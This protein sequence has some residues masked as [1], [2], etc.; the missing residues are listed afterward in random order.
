MEVLDSSQ[1]D[2]VSRG[3]EDQGTTAVF[4]KTGS[5]EMIVELENV[6][7]SDLR[8]MQRSIQN[9]NERGWLKKKL[10][11]LTVSFKKPIQG[12]IIFLFLSSGC[13][14][15][16]SWQYQK[17]WDYNVDSYPVDRQPLLSKRVAVP[18]FRDFRP[19]KNQNALL[20]PIIPLVPFG[21]ADYSTPETGKMPIISVLPYRWADDYDSKQ[22][23]TFFPAPVWQFRPTED[24]AK[25]AAD[26]INAS[27][28]FKETFFSS[29]ASDG[30]I[31]L[32]GDIK[33]T[34][35]LGEN[36]YLW[37]LI[38]CICCVDSRPSTGNDP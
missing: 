33:S 17:S 23:L 15:Q 34:P 32:L 27:G 4:L 36:F 14:S 7:A 35:L 9:E 12:I 13:A 29:D 30:D 19:D 38:L 20:L 8:A 28:L 2:G 10:K 31:V 26:E 16:R 18:P 21:W 25:A 1:T 6:T 3:V 37:S 11:R 24:L 5:S 22:K